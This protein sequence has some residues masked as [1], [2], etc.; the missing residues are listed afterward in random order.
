[1]CEVRINLPGLTI[2]DLEFNHAVLDH[3]AVR[4]LSGCHLA[5]D[6]THRTFQYISPKLIRKGDVEAV[7][8]SLSFRG[9][10]YDRVMD[11]LSDG[12]KS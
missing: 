10:N 1:M 9:Q 11:R 4:V 8:L 3:H 12:W 5:C 2:R 6:I 7:D